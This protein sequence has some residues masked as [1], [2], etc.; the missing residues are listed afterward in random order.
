MGKLEFG[1]RH[2]KTLSVTTTKKK[3]SKN[4][5]T[6]LDMVNSYEIHK[7]YHTF[8]TFPCKSLGICT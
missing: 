3:S 6:I 1:R 7:C 2:S 8:V 4:G 5:N